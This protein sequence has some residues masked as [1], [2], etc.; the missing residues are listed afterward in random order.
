M[1]TINSVNTTTTSATQASQ[2]NNQ[3]DKDLFLKILTTQ[4]RNQD[5]TQPMEDR[6]FVAQ[7]AQFSSLEQLT[8]LNQSINQFLSSQTEDISQFSNMMNKQVSWI[9]EDTGAQETG[10]I[11][12]IIKKDHQ[13]FYQINDEKIPVGLV[14]SVTQADQTT[15]SNQ[16]VK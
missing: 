13:F 15:T 4:L 9:N 11:K 3:Y 12:G 8:S 7:L 1:T 10:I 2:Q 16:E 5:P 14:T 6:E